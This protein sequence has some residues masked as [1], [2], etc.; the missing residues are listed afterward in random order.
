MYNSSNIALQNCTFLNSLGQSIALSEVSGIV[1]TNSYNFTHNHHNKHGAT[2]YYSSNGNINTKLMIN[3]CIFDHNKGI[4][5][6]YLNSSN[7]S[8]TFLSVEN[9]TF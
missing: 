6:I 3:H 8:Q 5:I 7:T 1:N 9:S 2:I 4:S